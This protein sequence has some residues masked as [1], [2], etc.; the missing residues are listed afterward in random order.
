[1]VLVSEMAGPREFSHNR[2]KHI[3]CM[4]KTVIKRFIVKNSAVSIQGCCKFPYNCRSRN[5]NCPFSNHYG[6]VKN[7]STDNINVNKIKIT[8]ILGLQLQSKASPETVPF[9]LF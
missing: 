9:P 1:M 6:D 2:S 7:S 8:L 4:C 3:F 5:K